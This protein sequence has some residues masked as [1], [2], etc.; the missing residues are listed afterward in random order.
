MTTLLILLEPI[1]G[2]WPVPFRTL[3]LTTLMVPTMVFWLI[4][5]VSTRI[6][7]FLTAEPGSLCSS[8][9]RPNER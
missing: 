2:E 8:M 7:D 4:P 9:Q 6:G 3:L 1:V 5:A